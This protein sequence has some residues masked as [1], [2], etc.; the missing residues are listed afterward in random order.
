MTIRTL[1]LLTL[2]G[3]VAVGPSV[4]PAQP[5][6]LPVP[7]HGPPGAAGG[8]GPPPAGAD[9]GAL[10]QPGMGLPVPAPLVAAKFVTPKGVRATAYPGASFSRMY[11]AASVVGLRPGYVYR[12]ELTNIPYAPGKALYPEVEVRGTLVPRPGMKYMSY[13]LPL[14]L[15]EADIEKALK[16]VLITKVIYLEDPDKALP[17]QVDRDAPV[18]MPDGTDDAAVKAALANGRLMAIMRVGNLK[19][20]DESLRRFAIE[21]TILLPGEKALRAPIVPPVFAYFAC[22][23]YDPLLGPKGPKEECILDGG[24]REDQLG[25]GPGD[26]LGGL[27][28]TDVG[29]EFTVGGKRRVTTSNVVCICSPRFMI[30]RAELL[31]SGL[32]AA[33]MV[34][35]H[36]GAQGT[37]LLKDRQAAMVGV[38][39]VYPTGI[40]GSVRPAAYVGKVG[41]SFY[42]GSSR[43][44]AVGQVDGVKVTGALVEPEQLTAF[45]TVCP[46]TVT[47][48]VDPPGPKE[49]G[50]VVTITIRYANT[51]SKEVSDLVV[52][53]SLSGRLEYVTGSGQTDR[54]ANFTVTE[55]EVGSVV[56]RWDL[57]GTLLPGQ[58]GTVRFKAKVR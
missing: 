3:A 21:G 12:F 54:P 13:P 49:P 34:T 27:N 18:E 58:S 17:T 10:M 46:L 44:Q 15:S 51:G 16:G 33:Q 22:P 2:L 29:V 56:V 28:P 6:P 53:D 32:N 7:A 24:D 45:P 31:P 19:P 47:K 11:D 38:G 26:R 52:S 50:A 55:N 20:A 9:A 57:P 43:P 5:G 8:V 37:G 4:A 41:L 42:L 1:T 36:V 14:V 25:V 35:I 30:R 48:S 39:H 23:M 40:E